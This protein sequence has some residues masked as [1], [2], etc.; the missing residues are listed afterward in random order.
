[1][2]IESVTIRGFRCFDDTG[3]TIDLDG[4]NCF[5][6]PNASGKTAAM[7]A[8]SRLFGES[9]GQRQIEPADFHLAPGEDLRGRSPRRLII[10]CKLC[11]PELAEDAA[12]LSD[13]VPEVFNQMIVDEPD[14]SPYC[15]IR[16][17]ATWSDD[18]TLSGDISQ[19]LWWVL[20]SSDNQETIEDGNRRKV[21]PGDRGKIRVVYVPAARNPDLQIKATTSTS[22]GRLIDMLAWDEGADEKLKETL[23]TISEQLGALTGIQTMNSHVQ[24]AWG[25]VYG[26]RV[27]REVSFQAMETDPAALVKLLVPAFHPGED[28]RIIHSG[29]LSDG[30]RSLFSLSLSLGFFKVEDFLRQNAEKAGFKAEVA[31]KMPLLTFFAVEEPENHLSPHYLGL[32]VRELNQIAGDSRAQVVLSSHSP[33]I[34]GRVQPDDVRYFLGH[35]TKRSTQVKSI[36][37]PDDKADEAF[38]YV[39]EAVRGFPELYFSRLVILGEGPSEE[40]VLRRLFEASGAP[41]DTHFISVVPL[42]GR[43]VNH[44]WRLLHGLNIPFLTL[45]DLDREKEGAGWGRVQ[46]VRNQLVKRYGKGHNEL[47]YS[48]E[49]GNTQSLDHESLNI[50]NQNSATDI[51]A[52]NFWIIHFENKYGIYFSSPLDLDF[53]M[54]EAFPDEYKGLAPDRGGPRLPEKGTEE[55]YNKTVEQRMRQVLAS[56]ASTASDTLGSTYQFEQKEL[57]PWYK[58]LFVDGS[59][60]VHHMRALLSIEDQD[61]A[62]NTP[63]TLR[64]L[65]KKATAL[66]QSEKDVA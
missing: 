46:Y 64:K 20:T 41:L 59:K 7:M 42:G 43:H 37:L 8:L 66:V 52:M 47:L 34:L 62:A 25:N 58:Y 57:F 13:V 54:L 21:L 61:L 2:K 9:R 26:G 12:L 63:E 60:P 38:K 44:F 32:I 28:G 6:G 23:G 31:E 51:E 36:P 27:A 30:L 24:N 22:F 48:T 5:V 18:G 53:A 55:E 10:E 19:E 35:E 65:V 50:L 3:E 17:E 29:D 40:I 16:L 49:D 39:R 56:D 15:R 33:S 4:F 11:F 45:L 14:G 1:M